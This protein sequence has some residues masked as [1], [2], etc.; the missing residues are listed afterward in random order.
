MTSR[1]DVI[2]AA[3]D[4]LADAERHRRPIPPL[5][6]DGL[7]IDEAYQVQLANVE[8]RLRQGD[9]I[10]G[11]KIGLTSRVVQEALGVAEPDYGH[12]FASLEAGPRVSIDALV[13][14]RVEGEVAFVLNADLPT[15]GVDADAVLAAT[16]CVVA[17]IE[18]V[19]SR[20]EDWKITIVDTVADNASAVAT[21]W[22]RSGSRPAR[23]ISRRCGWNCSRTTRWSTPGWVRPCSATRPPRWPGSP[24]RSAPTASSSTPAR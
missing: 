1:A 13:A 20:I 22:E 4:R 9:R 18:I 17:S 8:R 10:T 6:D 24:T 16:A 5:V 2:H 15:S 23:W 7:T 11:K 14:P 12:L 3:A 19:D 21:C